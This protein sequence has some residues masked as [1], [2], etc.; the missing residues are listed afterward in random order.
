[1][2]EYKGNLTKYTNYIYEYENALDEQKCDQIRDSLASI[3]EGNLEPDI[4]YNRTRKNSGWVLPKYKNNEIVSETND[5]L[6][7]FAYGMLK[8]YCED[9]TLVRKYCMTEN[10]VTSRM[11]YRSYQE[12][13]KYDWHVDY[14]HNIALHTSFLLY[15]NDD[16]EGGDTL[17]LNDK[18]RVRPK[19]GSVLMFPCGPYFIHK[20]TSI[21]T[22]NKSVIWNCYGELPGVL[23]GASTSYE[24]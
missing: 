13:D 20:S 24:T 3:F 11:I 14:D 21:K 8:Q 10:K 6:E 16:F 23:S 4:S 2:A 5:F 17:F 7:K 1:M 15:L 18:L 12:N 9:C 22:G 19:K